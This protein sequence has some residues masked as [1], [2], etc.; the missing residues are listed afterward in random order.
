MAL[1]QPLP[2]AGDL[3]RDHAIAARD[4]SVVIPMLDE[5][6]NVLPLLGE[7][8]AALTSLPLSELSSEIVV[9][10]DGSRDQTPERLA[11]A[12]RAI[13]RLR[14]VRHQM[15][16]GQSTALWSGISEARGAWIATL[17]GDG[18]NDPADIRRLYAEVQ[19]GDA[20]DIVLVTGVRR[21][22]RDSFIKRISSRIAN[23][24]RGRLL[25]DRVPD[26]ACGLKLFRR[27]DYL[28]LPRFDHM[29]RFLPALMGSQG[30]IVL[31]DVNH[32]PRTR[33]RSK[34][35]TLDRL[36]VGIGDLIGVMWLK[37]R[38]M[39]PLIERTD[40]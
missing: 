39:R 40:D 8:E 29:H 28:V 4:L 38:L 6:E 15:R 37:R 2:S 17:D 12:K 21:Q 5:A 18:Q 35:G 13:G 25:G 7:V 34:Y 10:D 26:T 11:E 3:G 27:R 36:W 24:V 33:G 9:V 22:R 20:R 30:R 14:V 23:A 16:C 1:P 31:V 19:G 32:R